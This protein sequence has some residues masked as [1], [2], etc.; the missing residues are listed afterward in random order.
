MSALKAVEF[1]LEI[2]RGSIVVDTRDPAAF[3][4]VH[5]RGAYSIWLQ[6]LPDF[7]GLILPRDRPLLLL[8]ERANDLDQ[9]YYS[10]TRLG[11]DMFRGYHQ[12]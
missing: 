11:F 5:I 3:G 4:G 7:A 10:L 12:Q 9:A 8:T 1:K 6:G 2:D